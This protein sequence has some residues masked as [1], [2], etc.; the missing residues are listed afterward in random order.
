VLWNNRVVALGGESV[1]AA[2]DETLYLLD[3]T[4][5]AALH[6]FRHSRYVNQFVALDRDRALS[7]SYGNTPRLWDLTTG[8][9]LRVFEGH[10][11]YVNHLIALDG[12]R[13]LSAS[14]DNTLRLW[15]LD[16]GLEIARLTSDTPLTAIA[17]A[18][19]KRDVL[20]AGDQGGRVLFLR[21]TKSCLH[22]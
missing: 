11:H 3:V 13:V 20:V 22:S 2:C 17:L 7:G 21:L 8:A 16:S 5:G 15:D 4:T 18:K 6:I 14:Y 1:L 12:G 19:N 9:I 10:S